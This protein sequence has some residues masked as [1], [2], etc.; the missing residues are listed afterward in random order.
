MWS[1]LKNTVVIDLLRDYCVLIRVLK[2]LDCKLNFIVVC[3]KIVYVYDVEK[4]L[5]EH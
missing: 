1:K 3:S 2:M 4:C 5:I